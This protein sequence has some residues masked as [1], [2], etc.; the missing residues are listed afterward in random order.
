MDQQRHDLHCRCAHERLCRLQDGPREGAVPLGLKPLLVPHFSA[1]KVDEVGA[2]RADAL[3]K[4]PAGALYGPALLRA[5]PRASALGQAL[6]GRHD[7]PV[8]PHLFCP[9][10]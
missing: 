9:G 10:Q 5:R 8:A 7:R 2:V 3:Q 1:H 4:V 6:C